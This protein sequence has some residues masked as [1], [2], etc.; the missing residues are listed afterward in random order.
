MPSM[1][2]TS[3]AMPGRGNVPDPGF[4]GVDP[5][6]GDTMMEPCGST[7]P[8]PEMETSVAFWTSQLNVVWPPSRITL[9]W[10]TKLAMIGGS[11]G[12]GSGSTVIVM[13][14]LTVR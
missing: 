5:G 7:D 2:T 9:G 13:V 8:M 3:A 14:W 11:S 1:S 10:A 6:S 4:S 12:S